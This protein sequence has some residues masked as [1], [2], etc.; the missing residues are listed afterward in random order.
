LGVRADY[1]ETAAPEQA[2]SARQEHLQF[3]A[4]QV[5]SRTESAPV[6]S[7]YAIANV[8][9]LTRLA[10]HDARKAEEQLA[11]V[12]KYLSALQ[13]NS[14]RVAAVLEPI[15]QSIEWLKTEIS[16][17]K[18]HQSLVGRQAFPL[19]V[20]A[21]VNGGQLGAE[22]LQGKVVL[23]DFWAMYCAPCIATFPHLR[24]WRDKY[25]E[26]DLVIIGLTNYSSLDWDDEAGRSR[27]VENLSASDEQAALARFAQHHRLKHRFAIVAKDSK[28]LEKYGVTQIPQAVLVDREGKIR[29]I[30]VGGEADSVRDLEETIEE[31][32]K[33]ENA[34]ASL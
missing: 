29:L 7:A 14:P 9:A 11:N 19:E 22:D 8:A 34:E 4:E 15:R 31:L 21:W 13:N 3:L 28:L 12:E 24:R 23:L 6:V 26:N 2:E 5:T 16:T 18:T 25:S 17:A 20:D 33:M 1:A 30:R 32:V 10:R 27:P